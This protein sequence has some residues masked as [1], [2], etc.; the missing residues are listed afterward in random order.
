MFI[1]IILLFP[2]SYTKNMSLYTQIK[3]LRTKVPFSKRI[4]NWGQGVMMQKLMNQN[5]MKSIQSMEQIITFTTKST[6]K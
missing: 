3:Y 5:I 2:Y 6:R 4:T 1:L